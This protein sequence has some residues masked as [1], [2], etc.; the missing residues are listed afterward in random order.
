MDNTSLTG[1]TI[2]IVETDVE[3]AAPM[4]D[5]IVHAGG[6]VLTAY[7]LSRALLIARN[8]DLDDALI[9]F[10]FGGA[11]T[12]GQVLKERHVPH[13]FYCGEGMCCSSAPAIGAQA[14]QSVTQSASK[15]LGVF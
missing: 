3:R 14:M 4:Q 9:D 11:E 1:R 15:S 13:I 12:V 10:Q 6:R 7:S 8:A 5:R 2:L